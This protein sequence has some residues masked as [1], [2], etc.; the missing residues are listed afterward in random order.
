MEQISFMSK[1]IDDFRDFFK[2]DKEIKSFP[3]I[4]KINE[5]ISLLKPQFA[6]SDIQ[7]TL[8]QDCDCSVSGYPNE[9]MQVI[10]NILNNA[11]DAIIQ[12]KKEGG[13][14]KITT[15]CRTNAC[16]TTIEDNGGGI[17]K[18]VI[19]KIFDPYFTTKAPDK[20]TGIGLYMAKTI[21][22]KHMEGTINVTNT[23]NG[24]LFTIMLPRTK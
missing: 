18:Q 5:V 23:E 8:E 20:G 7:I 16:V 19:E 15:R 1:T 11:K 17:E 12:T 21:I 3:V 13:L 24:A 9:F 6:S 22:E 4:S 2:I 14:I 10:L